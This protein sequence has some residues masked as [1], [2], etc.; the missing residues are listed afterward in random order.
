MLETKWDSMFKEIDIYLTKIMES[1]FFFQKFIEIIENNAELPENNHFLVWIWENYLYSNSMGVRRLMDHDKR[2]N[3]LYNLLDE[4][5][6]NP[7]ILSRKRY[8]SLFEDTGFKNDDTLINSFFDK[9]V[10]EGK[11]HIQ[12]DDVRDDIEILEKK[13]EKLRKYINMR[14]AHIDRSK[15][16]KVPTIRDLDECIVWLEELFKKYYAIFYAGSY[17]SLVPIPQYPWKDIFKIPWIPTR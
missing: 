2:T 15:L 12:P 11:E 16:K 5:K 8:A 17:T 1:R 6:T 10:G 13:Y 9:L 4:I 14:I 3:S 7:E